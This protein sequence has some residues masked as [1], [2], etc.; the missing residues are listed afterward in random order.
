MVAL[1]RF[2]SEQANGFGDHCLLACGDARETLILAVAVEGG[3]EVE[4]DAGHAIGAQGIAAGSFNRIIDRPRHRPP[5]PPLGVRRLVMKAH[6]QGQRIGLT[7]Q[8][9]YFPAGQL[10]GG[11][12]EPGFGAHQRRGV[13]SES[14]RQ[15]GLAGDRADRR[16]RHLAHRLDRIVVLR[17]WI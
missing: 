3:F 9:G 5:R 2:A 1:Q 11:Q 4:A 12:R 14:E 8:L 17:H 15:F 7:A 16:R 6:L 13:G 10:A